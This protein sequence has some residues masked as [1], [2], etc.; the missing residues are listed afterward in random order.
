M[1]IYRTP[2]Y[3]IGDKVCRRIQKCHWY[4]Y[5]KICPSALWTKCFKVV[6]KYLTKN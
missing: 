2:F 6:N 1:N 4:N 3:T 5:N